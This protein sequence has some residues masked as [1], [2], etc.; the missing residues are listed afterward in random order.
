MSQT[1]CSEF[2]LTPEYREAVDERAREHYNCPREDRE[3]ARDIRA[4]LMRGDRETGFGR[5]RV[6]IPIPEESYSGGEYDSYVLKLPRQVSEKRRWSGLKQNRHEA[7]VW[8]ATQDPHLVP[9]VASDADGYWLVMPEGEEVKDRMET[10]FIAWRPEAE[11]EVSDRVWDDDVR[12]ANTV[13]LDGEY[14]LC[15]YGI[16]P[17]DGQAE[18]GLNS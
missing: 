4:P 10:G 12:V 1:T 11:R 3:K 14:R 15:D 6:V 13:K 16:S 7:E 9:V 17:E 2:R 5:G 18:R 8:S